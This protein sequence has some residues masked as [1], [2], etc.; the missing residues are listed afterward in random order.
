[1]DFIIKEAYH[2]LE[3]VKRLFKE[4]TE[5]LGVDLSFQHYDE[6]IAGLPG[7]YGKPYGRLYLAYHDAKAAGCIALRRFDQNTCELKR[8]YVR[9]EFRGKKA[10]EKLMKKAIADARMIGYKRIC[11]DTLFTLQNAV[12]LY[13]NLGFYEIPA[14]YHNPLKNVL[15]FSIDL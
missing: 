11:L 5:M 7:K 9:P 3:D 10:G 1:M 4:Y 13:R 6:E 12:H 14:Y 8:L 15:Y 2:N